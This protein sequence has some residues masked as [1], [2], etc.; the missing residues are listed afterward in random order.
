MAAFRASMINEHLD[1]VNIVRCRIPGIA[2]VKENTVYAGIKRA[3]FRFPQDGSGLPYSKIRYQTT[4][5]LA[6]KIG[7]Q[8]LVF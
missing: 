2:G 4:D 8:S 5:Y 6:F 3:E 7:G 1:S